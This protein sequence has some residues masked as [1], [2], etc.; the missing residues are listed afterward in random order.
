[1]STCYLYPPDKIRSVVGWIADKESRD[2]ARNVRVLDVA[3]A[4]S[5][6]SSSPDSVTRT[7]DFFGPRSPAATARRRRT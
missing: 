5:V 4:R 2:V 1:L 6:P 3:A 7:G